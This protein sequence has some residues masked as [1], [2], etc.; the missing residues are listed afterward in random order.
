MG[1]VVWVVCVWVWVMRRVLG[2]VCMWG[3]G[4]SWVQVFVGSSVCG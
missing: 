3:R 2:V 4:G 1:R